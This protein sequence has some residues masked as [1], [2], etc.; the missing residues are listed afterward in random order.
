MIELI[1]YIFACLKIDLFFTF[2]LNTM[3]KFLFVVALTLLYLTNCEVI[4]AAGVAGPTRTRYTFE[5]GWK[6][7]RSDHTDF[8]QLDYD[9]SRWQSVTVPHDWAVYGPFSIQND[10]QKVA[11]TQDGQKEAMEHAGRTGGLPFVG[12]GW[13]RL[14]FEVPAFDRSKKAT[15]VFDGAMS[16]ARV[17]INGKEAGYWP[18]GYNTFYLDVTPYL[19]AGG[20]NIM[21]VRLENDVESSRWYPGAGLYR[22]VHLIVNEDVHIPMWGTQL[23]TP[24]VKNDFA[25]VRLNTSLVMPEGKS[26]SSYR[27]VTEI[28]NAVGS[29]VC[30]GEKQLTDFD[31]QT[32]SQEFVVEKPELW[33]P[34]APYLYTAESKVYEGNVVKDESVTPFGIRSIEIIPNKGFF[35]NGKKNSV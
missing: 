24:V 32:F 33:T 10:R 35:L 27:I 2:N 13:Y 25:R 19:N 11:I 30:K 15:L 12:V 16:H 26:S 34:D 17:Y 22:N 20:K 18:Y 4:R 6:F 21:A 9:D 29:V 3:Q 8:S 7:I 14:D 28:K 31:G 1:L 5:K 23:S